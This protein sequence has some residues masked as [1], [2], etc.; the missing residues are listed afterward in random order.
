[1]EEQLDLLSGGS[2]G[3]LSYGESSVWRID[4]KFRFF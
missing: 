3:P 1:M 2:G 4:K